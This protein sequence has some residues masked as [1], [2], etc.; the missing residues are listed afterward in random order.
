MRLY[1]HYIFLFTIIF[2]YTNFLNAEAINI[3]ARFLNSIKPLCMR[4]KEFNDLGNIN[5]EET[6]FGKDISGEKIINFILANNKKNKYI[7]KAEV[8]NYMADSKNKL[9]FNTSSGIINSTDLFY[10]DYIVNKDGSNILFIDVFCSDLELAVGKKVDVFG[11]IVKKKAGTYSL[12]KFIEKDF[13]LIGY[14]PLISTDLNS[15]GISSNLI[16]DFIKTLKI[17]EPIAIINILSKDGRFDIIKNTKEIYDYSS[18]I[19]SGSNGALNLYLDI[20][21]WGKEQF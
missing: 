14:I 9:S 11:R 20:I 4:N 6:P 12:N 18:Y 16:F 2:I 3:K 13:K 21:I 5:I 10:G 15:A 19:S 1:V 8:L 17:K 7:L